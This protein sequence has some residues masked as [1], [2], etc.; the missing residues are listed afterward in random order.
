VFAGC[1][2]EKCDFEPNSQTLVK[3]GFR[4]G[5]ILWSPWKKSTP[6]GHGWWRLP[7]IVSHLYHHSTRSAFSVLDGPEYWKKWSPGPRGHRN[8]IRKMVT[9]GKIRIDTN[10]SLEDFLA[11]YE[12]TI[13]PHRWKRY[14]IARQKFLSSQNDGNIR[15]Y[16]AFVENKALA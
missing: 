12:K 11:A 15:I 4:H 1:V 3:Y 13:L 6:E 2:F 16:L 7:S 10:A 9:S 8:T 5:L 14:F